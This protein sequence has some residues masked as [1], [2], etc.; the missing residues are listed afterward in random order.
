[1]RGM[2]GAVVVG[3][4]LA[5]GTTG[6]VEAQARGY[7]GIGGGVTIPMGDFKDGYKA[8]W[9]GQVVGGV[10]IN[11]MFGVRVDGSYGQNSSKTTGGPK[12]KLVGALGDV[13]LSPKTSGGVAP[14][15]LAGAGMLNS[16]ATVSG[17]SAS[18][19]AFAWNA[20]AGAKFTAGSVGVYVEARFLS[21]K[22]NGATTNMIPVTVGLRFGGN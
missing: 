8:G 4:L 7:V 12:V 6:K 1:M 3:S 13:T 17:V 16:K 21:A 15:V 10:K 11:D 5:I 22:K 18:T 19:S 9:L 2:L 20:G 14:Y